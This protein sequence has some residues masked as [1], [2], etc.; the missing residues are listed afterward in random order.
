VRSGIAEDGKLKRINN[1]NWGVWLVG[2]EWN[3]PLAQ[4]L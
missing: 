1:D 4:C 3:Q 2:E